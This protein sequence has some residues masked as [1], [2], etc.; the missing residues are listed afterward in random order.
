[1]KVS[2]FKS[3]CSRV[4]IH[5]HSLRQFS[6]KRKTR[7]IKCSGVKFILKIQKTSDRISHAEVHRMDSKTVTGIALHFGPDERERD[8][9]VSVC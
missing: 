8:Q 2:C 7:F 9:L 1:M 3:H 6:P 5:C 4:V